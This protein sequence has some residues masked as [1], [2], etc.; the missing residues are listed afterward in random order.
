MGETKNA[1]S[2]LMEKQLGITTWTARKETGR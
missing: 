2:N 1:Y